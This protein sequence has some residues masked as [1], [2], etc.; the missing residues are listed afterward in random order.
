[1]PLNI[2]ILGTA[3][4]AYRRFLPALK[5][6]NKIQYYGIASRTIE[7][8][9]K[10]QGAFGG[11]CYDNYEKLLNDSNIQ[12]VYIPLPP[13]LH[14]EWGKKALEA[15]KHVFMEKPFCTEY[16]QTVELCKIANNENLCLHEN[17]MFVYHK[18]LDFIKKIMD[19][20]ILGNIRLIRIAFGFPRREGNDFR[21]NKELG[22]GAL[23]DCGG[24]TLKLSDILFDDCKIVYKKLSNENEKIDLYGNAVIESGDGNIAM[25]S[26]GMD[27]SYK[28]ELEIWGSNAVLKADR[29]FTAPPDFNVNIRILFNDR[30]E[31]VPIGCDNQ[32]LNSINYFENCIFDNG[33]RKSNYKNILRQ[34]ELLERMRS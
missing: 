24:Y 12:A 33:M 5:K 31:T 28:C 3:D 32:F 7:K 20:K 25:V 16:W 26:F 23:L 34:A 9:K 17:Y 10:F 8:T 4:I 19:K 30:V 14:Y 6:S 27:N 13:A 29:I 1:M 11:Y 22:G 18:Q 15:G 2:G 21:Y